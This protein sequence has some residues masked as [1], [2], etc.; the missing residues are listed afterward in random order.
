MTTPTVTELRRNGN[1][2]GERVELGRYHLSSGERVIEGQR[3]NGAVRISDVSVGGGGRGYLI[4]CELEEDGYDALKAL[5]A[6]YPDG[7]VMPV[8]TDDELV[9]QVERHVA[10]GHL[11]LLGQVSPD[12]ILGRDRAQIGEEE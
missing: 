12:Q 4:E 10:E 7:L 5:V 9:A 11:N 2:V 8:E 1:P 6:D 3:V